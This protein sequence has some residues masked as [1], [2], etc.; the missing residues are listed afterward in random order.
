MAMADVVDMLGKCTGNE[1]SQLFACSYLIGCLVWFVCAFV[2][3]LEFARM[4][5]KVHSLKCQQVTLEYVSKSAISFTWR[6]RSCKSDFN[7]PAYY[8][9]TLLY[10]P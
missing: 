9:V 4:S 7:I 5:T 2:C 1:L 3:V 6:G 8:S 10:Q